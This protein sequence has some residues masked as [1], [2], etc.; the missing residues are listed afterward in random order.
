MD[1]DRLKKTV[2]DFVHAQ[3]DHKG[4][5]ACSF[6]EK[7]PEHLQLLNLSHINP[8]LEKKSHETKQQ[9]QQEKLQ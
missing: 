7:K 5:C 1:L 4:G 6:R 3:G 9:Q 2:D 8:V